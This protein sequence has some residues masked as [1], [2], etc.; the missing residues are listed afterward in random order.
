M[1]IIADKKE[2]N[3]ADI[4]AYM[5]SKKTVVCGLID[6][7]LQAMTDKAKIDKATVNQLSTALGTVID[8]FTMTKGINDGVEDKVEEL[9]GEI[10][11]GVKEDEFE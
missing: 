7:Y 10:K 4:L 3:S 8:K 9:F 1:R 5:E 6:T 11:K 2:E